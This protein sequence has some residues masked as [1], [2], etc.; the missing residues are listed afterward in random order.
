MK[1]YNPKTGPYVLPRSIYFRIIYLIKD[2][3]R[4]LSEADAL[5]EATPPPTETPEIQRQRNLRATETNNLRY[6]T[7]MA[8][9]RD[10]EEAL[11]ET[12]PPD[13]RRAILASIINGEKYPLDR[14]RRTY[15]NYKQKYIH[16]LAERKHL[17]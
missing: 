4:L 13:A 9:V 5:L 12:V 11:K 17:I 16:N 6:A 14:D 15:T 8:D 2:Y 10:I 1:T 3:P 7:I